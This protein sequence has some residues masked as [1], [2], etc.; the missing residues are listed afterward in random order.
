VEDFQTAVVIPPR[1]PL[2]FT[3]VS[4]RKR[5]LFYTQLARMLDAGIAPVRS[6]QTLGQQGISM[7]LSRAAL[8]VAAHIQDGG[9]LA[10]GLAR[11]PNYF[12]ANEIRMI[13]ASERT[14][15]MAET[16]LRIARSL[17]LLTRFSRKLT[18][19][20]IYPA[21][22]LLATYIFV[23]LLMAILFDVGGGPAKLL[24]AKGERLAVGFGVCLAVLTVWRS[25]TS[26]SPVRI[27]LYR[28]LLWVP[29]F[30]TLSRRL[31]MARFADALECLYAA[32]VPTPE[33]LARSAAACGNAALAARLLTAV[34]LVQQGSRITDAL[35][36]SGA[37]PLMLLNMV[38][39][40]EESGKLDESLHKVA[41]YQREDAEVT[42]DRLSKMLPYLV[43]LVVIGYLAFL[44]LHAWGGMLKLY[45]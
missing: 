38:E 42:I 5:S 2:P 6:L 21:F 19:G 13:E 14:G 4:G 36:A 27:V 26:L 44:V 17:E 20:M 35:Q 37:V 16:M 45:Q 34:P 23:P 32:G 1:S 18:T 8:D 15:K 28:L 30:G 33:A 31:A 41:E 3:G 29:V 40:G 10:G 9:T 12:P 25:L 43:V 39:V 11:H 7:R 24:L 22:L